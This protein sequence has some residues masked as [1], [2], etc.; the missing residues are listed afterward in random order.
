MKKQG[1][2]FLPRTL[3]IS[4]GISSGKQYR[5]YS[6]ALGKRVEFLFRGSG[7]NDVIDSEVGH[8]ELD[9]IKGL[10]RNSEAAY[11]K[12]KSKSFHSNRLFVRL[13]DVFLL[14]L[15]AVC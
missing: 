15:F 6:A 14:Y 4:G 8:E 3:L 10:F 9:F 13:G 11:K 2:Q 1:Y 12:K 7:G 5:S